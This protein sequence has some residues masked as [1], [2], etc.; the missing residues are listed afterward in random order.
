MTYSLKTNYSLLLFLI[1]SNISLARVF[2]CCF[3]FYLNIGKNHSPIWVWKRKLPCDISRTHNL[4]TVNV[5]PSTMN[6][7][8]LP[9]RDRGFRTRYF[10]GKKR[11]RKDLFYFTTL[12]STDLRF[13]MTFAWT[14]SSHTILN[15]LLL[16][17]QA[18]RKTALQQN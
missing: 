8:T 3:P 9:K 2:P 15:L 11:K 4:F 16:E 17:S 13:D 1:P 18:Q 7:M 12:T 6:A 10:H 14:F 5:C